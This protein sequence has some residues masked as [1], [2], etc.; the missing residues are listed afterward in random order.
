MYKRRDVVERG[1]GRNKQWR[2]IATRYDELTIM[3]RAAAVLT[4]L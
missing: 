2:A 1:F 3:Y 4:Q